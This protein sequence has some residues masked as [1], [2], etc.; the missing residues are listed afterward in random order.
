M[1]HYL[2]AVALADVT[3]GGTEYVLI[4]GP[5]KQLA[6]HIPGWL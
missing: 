5:V 3:V 4:G 2:L 6:D 1:S